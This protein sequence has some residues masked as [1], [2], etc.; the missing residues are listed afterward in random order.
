M[1]RQRRIE[2]NERLVLTGVDVVAQERVEKGCDMT[3]V[4]TQGAA[5]VVVGGVE[6]GGTIKSNRDWQAGGSGAEATLIG[7]ARPSGSPY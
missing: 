6:V 1:K 7:V 5:E 4:C 3:R 2:S